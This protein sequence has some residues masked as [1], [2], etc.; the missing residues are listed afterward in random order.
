MVTGKSG[1]EKLV[2]KTTANKRSLINRLL[3]EIPQLVGMLLLIPLLAACGTQP[4]A[5][6]L[7][8]TPA[9]EIPVQA[10]LPPILVPQTQMY[11]SP[12]E[13]YRYQSNGLLPK[14][15]SED[16]YAKWAVNMFQLEFRP[17][18][19]YIL[20]WKADEFNELRKETGTFFLDYNVI[21]FHPKGFRLV[22]SRLISNCI[23]AAA[24]ADHMLTQLCSRK[25]IHASCISC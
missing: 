18:G 25:M 6:N 19:N 16:L 10:D 5:A 24:E 3:A 12:T 23:R 13:G 11:F 17:D 14:I 8:V 15:A 22:K 2:E 4:K 20:S 9:A 7:E 21:T 1:R